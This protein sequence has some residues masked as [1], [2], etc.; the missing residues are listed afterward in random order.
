VGGAG[1]EGQ[2]IQFGNKV[3]KGLRLYRYFDKG[4]GPERL[5][6]TNREILIYSRPGIHK[7]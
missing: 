3:N 5:D 6:G 1:V 2:C 4:K 7:K